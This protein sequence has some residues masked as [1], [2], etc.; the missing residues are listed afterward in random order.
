[1]YQ[2]IAFCLFILIG[3]S[4]NAQVVHLDQ[5]HQ[6]MAG[7]GINNNWAP[8][9]TAAVADSLFD[10]TRGLGLSILRIGMGSNGEAFNGSSWNDIK[11]AQARG[12]KYVIGSAWTPPAS[13]KTNGSENDGGYLLP[14]YYGQW[15]D[16][17]AA[18]PAKVKAG[19]GMDLYAMSLGNEPDFASCGMTEPCNGNYPTTL[20][21]DTQMVNFIKVAG[22]KIHAAG[23]RVMAP[24]A[25]EWLHTW[26]DSSA[27]CSEPSG[28]PSSNP[29]HGPGYDY[30]H[31]LY[32]DTAAWNQ[33]DIL[34]VHQYDSQIAEPWPSDVPARKPVWQTEM[35]GVKWWPEQGPSSDINNGVACAGWFHNALTVGEANGWCWWWWQ[36]TGSTNEGLLLSN[37]TNT[38][39][40]YTFGNYSRFV[41]PG[42]PSSRR[43]AR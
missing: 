25:S 30:G 7:F 12:L 42:S 31:A 23:C 6:T 28:R 1:M 2:R 35:S 14:Q 37:G 19:S 11:L 18:F 17:L 33:L 13:W 36:A 26:S 21:N 43:S 40:H 16:R 5:T 41:R 8:A 15:S 20:M 29:L 4:V 9:L 24:E 3:L 10:S 39:R 32:K 22:P 38:K 27:C 34:G